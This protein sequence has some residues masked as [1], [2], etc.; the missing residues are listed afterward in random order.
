MFNNLD[1]EYEFIDMHGLTK[2][3]CIKTLNEK[4]HDLQNELDYKKLKPN[5]GDGSSHVF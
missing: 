1:H 3:M 4:L 5:S 2:V